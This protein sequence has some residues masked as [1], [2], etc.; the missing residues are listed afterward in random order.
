[1]EINDAINLNRCTGLE[2]YI[3]EF[4]QQWSLGL[5]AITAAARIYVQACSKFSNAKKVFQNRY[6]QYISKTTW[7]RIEMIGRNQLDAKAI[8]FDSRTISKICQMPIDLQNR[9][10]SF[11]KGVRV[12]YGGIRQERT[13]PL[14]KLTAR[15]A[16]MV[17]DYKTGSVRS[18]DEQ[19]EYLKTKQVSQIVRRPECDWEIT[20]KGLKVNRPTTFSKEDLLR[21]LE[22][23]G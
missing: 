15:Q 3:K 19:R 4:G 17:F 2:D 23:I 9:M 18:I 5:T 7:D 6:G 13:V 12:L 8:T 20:S 14:T 10:L 21:I 16:D 11:G 22:Q 1:M